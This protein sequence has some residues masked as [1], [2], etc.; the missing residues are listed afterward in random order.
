MKE[1]M[2]RYGALLV[3]LLLVVLVGCEGNGTERSPE[4]YSFQ[5]ENCTF[6]V[7][8][9]ADRVIASL[10]KANHFSSAPSC[11]GVG[12]DELYVYNGF[13]I[14][15][16]RDS[17]RAEII[18]IELTNDTLSTPEAVRIGDSAERL[19]DVYGKGEDFSGGIEYSRANC[20][21]RFFLREGRIIGI[22][23]LKKV[24]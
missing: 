22:R 4:E 16:H 13:K 14:T 20:I 6:S 8:D 24:E 17:E 3:L 11:A 21:L 18:M 10:G 7:G 15:A 2:N 5:V 23:Y 1:T 9:D 19:T 12:T